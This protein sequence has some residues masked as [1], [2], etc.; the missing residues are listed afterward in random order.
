MVVDLMSPD[1]RYDSL[2][3]NNYAQI[4]LL[5]QIGSLPGRGRFAARVAADLL[6]ARVGGSGQDGEARA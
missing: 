3:L 6:D 5:N 1:D 4:N 2:F